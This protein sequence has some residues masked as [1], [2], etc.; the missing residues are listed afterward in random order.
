MNSSINL[1]REIIKGI[2]F[3]NESQLATVLTI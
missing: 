2:Q 3:V 1:F